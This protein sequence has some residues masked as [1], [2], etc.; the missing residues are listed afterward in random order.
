M[1]PSAEFRSLAVQLPLN[2]H[3]KL[4]ERQERS[5]DDRCSY[6]DLVKNRFANGGSAHGVSPVLTM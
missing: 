5:D 2:K 4:V 3:S 1:G 6:C